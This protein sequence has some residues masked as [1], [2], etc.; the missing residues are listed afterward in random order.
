MKKLWK[1]VLSLGLVAVLS[2]SSLPFG[3]GSGI[4]YAAQENAKSN[5]LDEI[6]K[7]QSSGPYDLLLLIRQDK[8]ADDMSAQKAAAVAQ[9]DI[10]EMLDRAL[11][12]GKVSSYESFFSSN[13]IHVIASDI[14][15]IR[16]LAAHPSVEDIALI[17]A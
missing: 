12:Q 14:D 15:F 3:L 7:K 5:H 4:A 9:N 1:Q 10:K 13:S 6:L 11:E 16:Q 17:G 2:C 8:N